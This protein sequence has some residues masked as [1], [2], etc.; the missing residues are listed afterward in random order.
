MPEGIVLVMGLNEEVL[1]F[2]ICQALV[3]ATE[4]VLAEAGEGLVSQNL[5]VVLRVYVEAACFGDKSIFVHNYYNKNYSDFAVN[6]L[7][8]TYFRRAYYS[9]IFLYFLY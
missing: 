2:F 4:P 5:W 6:V 3:V 8:R 1:V 7:S 9:F